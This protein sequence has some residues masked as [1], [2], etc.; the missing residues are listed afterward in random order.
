VRVL[1][2]AGGAASGEYQ[3]GAAPRLL[4]FS[5]DERLLGALRGD[6]GVEVWQVGQAQPFARL[7]A[8]PDDT[9]L[10][11]SADNQ[12]AISGGPSGV[13]VFSLPGGALL[14]ALPV[15]VDDL[16]LGPRRRVLAL[17]HDGIIQLW[18][19]E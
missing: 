12:L 19:V 2:P 5:P 1:S 9:R 14:R 4:A 15:A 10:I 8:K 11:F 16:A 6:G 3:A 13:N 7:A 18:G 17:L